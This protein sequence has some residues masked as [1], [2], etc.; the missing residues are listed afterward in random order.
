MSTPHSLLS[1]TDDL[2]A[3]LPQRFPI[4]PTPRTHAASTHT[5]TASAVSSA[6]RPGEPPSSP[7]STA[8]HHTSATH[9]GGVLPAASFFRPSRPNYPSSLVRPASAMSTDSSHE[10]SDSM[11]MASMEKRL[12]A[13]SDLSAQEDPMSTSEDLPRQSEA[14]KRTKQSREALLPI[15]GRSTVHKPKLHPLPTVVDEPRP[16]L[17]IGSSGGSKGGAVRNS[18]ERLFRGISFDG[19]RKSLS[20][21]TIETKVDGASPVSP[22]LFEGKAIDNDHL[23]PR[24]KRSFSP[25]YEPSISPSLRHRSDYEFDPIPPPDN[26]PLSAV[27]RIDERTGKPMRNYQTHP[28]RNRFFLGGHVLTGGDQPWAFISSF[29]VALGISGVWFGTTCVWWWHHESPAVAA[30]GAYMCLLTLSSMLATAMRDPG[31]LPRDLDLDPPM[32]A[33]STT[34][35]NSRVPLPRDLKVR[36]G[37][38]RVKYCVTCK[39]YRPP[40]SSHCKMCD[41]CVEGCD[42]HCQWVNNCVGRRNYTTFFTFLSSATTT[43]ALVIVTSAL[44]LWWLTRRDHV[45]FQH[46]LREGAGSAVAFCLSIVVI[47]PVTALL[48]YHLR[49]LL[50]NVTTIEQIRNQAHKTL[51]PGPPPPNPFSHGSMRKNFVN[52]LCRPTGYSWLDANG[53]A[54]VDQRKVNPGLAQWEGN[55]L[56]TGHKGFAVVRG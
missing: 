33:N 14:S 13:V 4:G 29:T 19:H 27:P 49:L 9:A 20:K 56:E 8:F 26:P 30:V 7:T 55:D 21:P 39:I 18:L 17:N 3:P 32:A 10:Q 43:L 53:T 48:I 35:D 38:V 50:L 1:R 24:A 6:S 2:V 22:I 36:A 11:P 5:R 52:V 51:V 54:T 15:G 42:H 12:S 25:P 45:N 34:D 37:S 46:A 40:R 16:P 47:W 31:I 44:H 41:N 28:S 23:V